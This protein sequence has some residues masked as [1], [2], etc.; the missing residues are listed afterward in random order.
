MT[1]RTAETHCWKLGTQA[2]VSGEQI[3]DSLSAGAEEDVEAAGAG[4]QLD[5]DTEAEEGQAVVAAAAVAVSDVVVFAVAV[6]NKTEAE[7]HGSVVL[8]MIFEIKH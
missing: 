3:R 8:Q 7:E 1:C 5:Q 6:E 4:H 2:E